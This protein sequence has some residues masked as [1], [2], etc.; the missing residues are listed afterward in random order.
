[1][2]FRRDGK[3]YLLKTFFA[4]NC[5]L[6]YHGV[7][8]EQESGLDESLWVRGMGRTVLEDLLCNTENVQL[9]C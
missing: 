1:M 2:T 7:G 8:E 9:L 4:I 6:K 3:K 5:L